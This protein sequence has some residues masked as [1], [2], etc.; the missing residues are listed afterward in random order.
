MN[1][2]DALLAAVVSFASVSSATAAELVSISFPETVP[3]SQSTTQFGPRTVSSPFDFSGIGNIINPNF[4]NPGTGSNASDFTLHQTVGTVDLS[5]VVV[6]YEFNTAVIID[7][8]DVIQH[9]NG[10]RTFEV[11]VGNSLDNMISI[12]SDSMAENTVEY[13]QHRFDYDTAL[14]GR[15][16]QL[17]VTEPELSGQGGWAYYRAFPVYDIPAPGVLAALGLGLTA[18]RRSR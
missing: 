8:F 11:L 16:V 12:G 17:R 6:T 1:K 3:L 10:V 7:A 2:F 18:T 9:H 4:A 13:A 5:N 14:A 15:F